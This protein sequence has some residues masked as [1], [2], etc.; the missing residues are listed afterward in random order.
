MNKKNFVPS[1]TETWRVL[2]VAEL[3]VL[4]LLF[5]PKQ[6]SSIKKLLCKQMIKLSVFWKILLKENQKERWIQQFEHKKRSDWKI[7]IRFQIEKDIQKRPIDK[8]ITEYVSQFGF[9][10][11]VMPYKDRSFNV[12]QRTPKN[13]ALLRSLALIF[14]FGFTF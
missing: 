8:Y 7:Q 10:S 9:F 13:P 2:L 5:N 6:I 4:S 14:I 1:A 3:E 11:Q 12:R